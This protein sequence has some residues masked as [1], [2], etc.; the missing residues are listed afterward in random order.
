MD[1]VKNSPWNRIEKN[2]LPRS[3][4]RLEIDIAFL[5]KEFHEGSKKS[6]ATGE[7]PLFWERSAQVISCNTWGFLRVRNPAIF[8]KE[9]MHNETKKVLEFEL[10]Q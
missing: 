4:A 1:A 5:E 9:V 6:L 2:V 7:L 10:L 8:N 3:S